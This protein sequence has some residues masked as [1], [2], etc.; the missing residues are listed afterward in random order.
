M[1]TQTACGAQAVAAR[2]ARLK[3]CLIRISLSPFL[4][5]Q[6]TPF[7]AKVAK[8]DHRGRQDYLKEI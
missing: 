5:E 8:N 1:Q 2:A 3:V 7:T 6:T 4:K